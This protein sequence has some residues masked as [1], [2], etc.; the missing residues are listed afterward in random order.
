METVEIEGI[1]SLGFHTFGGAD[2]QRVINH[3]AFPFTNSRKMRMRF[4]NTIY[5][6]WILSSG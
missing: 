2:D 6:G 4:H 3:S 1:D 5:Y